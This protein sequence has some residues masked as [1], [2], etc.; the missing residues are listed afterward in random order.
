MQNTNNQCVTRTVRR[1][2]KRAT[3]NN[4]IKSKRKTA[5][6]NDFIENRKQKNMYKADIRSPKV[7]K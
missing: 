2:K 1:K 4:K 6:N 5:K 7:N 3:L